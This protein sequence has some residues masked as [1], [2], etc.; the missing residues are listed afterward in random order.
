MSWQALLDDNNFVVTVN[1]WEHAVGIPCEPDTPLGYQWTGTAFVRPL[2]D[3]KQELLAAVQQHLDATVRTRGY[4]SMLSCC[5]YVSSTDPTFSAEALD[6]AAWRDAVWRYCY[7]V[8]A[9]FTAGTRPV[10][11]PEELISELPALV[12]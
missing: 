7:D 12:W 2:S 8:E 6:A 9:D 10:P 3:I 11:T 5:S 4:D 1:N